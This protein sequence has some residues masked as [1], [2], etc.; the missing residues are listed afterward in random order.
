MYYILYSYCSGIVCSYVFI[1]HNQNIHFHIYNHSDA[2]EKLTSVHTYVDKRG[3][4]E[5]GRHAIINKSYRYIY[6]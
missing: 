4:P 3:V 1:I 6:M 5:P 2:S